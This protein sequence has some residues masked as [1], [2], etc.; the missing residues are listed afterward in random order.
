VGGA[1]GET[2]VNADRGVQIGVGLTHDRGHRPA[3]RHPGYVHPVDIDVVLDCQAGWT[4]VLG[5]G[6]KGMGRHFR[7][8][9]LTARIV[10]LAVRL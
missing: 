9:N 2:G 10:C 5:F 7:R 3:C 6:S 8:H 4:D 1:G